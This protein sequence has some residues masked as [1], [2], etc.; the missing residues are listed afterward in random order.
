MALIDTIDLSAVTRKVMQEEGWDAETAAKAERRYRRFL[1]MM[2]LVPTLD[3]VPT[4]DIDKVWHQ[5]IL[6][7]RTY[8]EDCQRIF[9]RY[10]HHDPASGEAGEKAIL[11]DGLEKTQALYFELFGEDYIEGT[12]LSYFLT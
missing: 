4:E 3:I 2:H 11:H 8:S 10:I 6:F 1:C 9:G 12:W 5:H 7:T